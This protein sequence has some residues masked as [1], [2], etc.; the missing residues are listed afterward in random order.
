MQTKLLDLWQQTRVTTLFISHDLEEAIFMANRLL[1]LTKRPASVYREF[2]ID[3]AFPRS[4]EVLESER[5][6][7]LRREALAAV[8][9]V[10]NS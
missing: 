4:N 10:L 1:I 5:F 9:E 3:I 6:T 8:R 7:T 2:A